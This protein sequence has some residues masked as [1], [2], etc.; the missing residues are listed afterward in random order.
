[1]P[2]FDLYGGRDPRHIPLYAQREAAHIVG[3]SH[4]T[5]RSWVQEQTDSEGMMPPLIRRPDE[6]DSR[7]SFSN[8]VE[9]FVLRALRERYRVPMKAIRQAVAYAEA[10]LDVKHLLLRRELRVSGDLFWD[11][12]G[13]LINLSQ[14][15]QLAIRHVLESYLERIEWDEQTNLPTRFFPLPDAGVA[16]KSVVVDPRVAFGHPTLSGTGISTEVV[17][18]RIDIGE[19]VEELAEDYQVSIKQVKDALLYERP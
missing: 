14:S 9:A 6:A 11:R 1:M 15:G 3:V 8:L 12:L 13:Q 2:P 10:E 4:S 18:R 19:T 16:T 17:K 5:L 7:L